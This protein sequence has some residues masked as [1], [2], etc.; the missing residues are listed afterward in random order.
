MNAVDAMVM[1]QGMPDQ[2]P[3][4][5]PVRPGDESNSDRLVPT[6]GLECLTHLC[7]NCPSTSL[8]IEL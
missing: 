2:I 8:D 7:L 3:K 5:T 4:G 6:I 1:L